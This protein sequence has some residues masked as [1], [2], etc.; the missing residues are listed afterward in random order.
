[1][2]S[3]RIASLLFVALLVSNAFAAIRRDPNGVNVNSQGATTV[4]FTFGGLQGQIPVEAFWCGELIPA[5]P[6]IGQRCAP[7][8]IF[9]RL[10]LR[11]DQ[12]RVNGGTFTDIMSI[13]ANVARRAYQAAE[14]GQT[15]SFFYVRRF[16]SSSGAPDEYVFVTCRMA[17]V[18]ARTPLAL[19][20]VKVQFEIDSPLL[21]VRPGQ[22]PPPLFAEVRFNGTGRLRG[23]WEVVVPGNEVPTAEDLLTE[24]SLPPE[25]R[26]KQRRYTA[27]D[28]FNVFLPPTGTARV[29]GP[30]PSKLPTAIE[31]LYM[32]LFRVEASDD[33]ESDS[34]LALAGAG[35][36]V[37]HSGAVAGFP[38]PPLR[39]YVGN[40]GEVFAPGGEPQIVLLD[41]VAGAHVE[42]GAAPEFSWREGGSA[43][44]YRVDVRNA[45]GETVIAAIVPRGQLH[46]AAPSWFGEKAGTGRLMWRVVA[47]SADGEDLGGSGWRDLHALP[48]K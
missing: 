33:K 45:S 36:G 26:G 43:P 29:P 7:G 44:F 9:G 21:P 25:L 42:A 11:Y 2:K 41:P 18:G 17:G 22:T 10:P 14:A 8:S 31:G 28:R 16:V 4:F 5:A 32:V 47:L 12:S 34:N 40:A 3:T 24:A 35:N 37:V 39:Y 19:T 13:P 15:S 1:M 27:I 46:Y 48:G 30:D 20:D 23:R 38:M 6:A